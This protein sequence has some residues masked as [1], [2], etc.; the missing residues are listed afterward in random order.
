MCNWFHAA[1]QNCAYG[2]VPGYVGRATCTAGRE[3]WRGKKTF[4]CWRVVV[5]TA[6][7]SAGGPPYKL[8]CAL[9]THQHHSPETHRAAPGTELPEHRGGCPAGVREP[10]CCLF[11]YSA[12][13]GWTFTVP[14]RR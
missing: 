10:V 4:R 9:E 5:A 7:L 2:L 12:H 13:K 14:G 11:G 3:G 1:F 8:V 6:A